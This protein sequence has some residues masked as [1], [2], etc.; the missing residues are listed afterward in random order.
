M[1]SETFSGARALFTISNI[2]IGYSKSFSGSQAVNY[3]QR[4]V[5]GLLQVSENVPVSYAAS[6]TATFFRVVGKDVHQQGI[7]PTLE[8]VLTA[9]DLMVA[10]TDNITNQNPYTFTGVRAADQ[11]FSVDAGSLVNETQNFVA[12]RCFLESE[13]V[14]QA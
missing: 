4:H 9:G 2:P 11:S 7:S 6:C 3:D 1:A 10:V 13:N 8:N 12:I 14:V 5:L